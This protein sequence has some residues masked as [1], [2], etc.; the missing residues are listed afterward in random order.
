MFH[1]L[2]DL[3]V[4]NRIY[5]EALREDGDAQAGR[6]REAQKTRVRPCHGRDLELG[7]IEFQM[8]TGTTIPARDSG[9]ASSLRV[10]GK[11]RIAAQH[12]ILQMFK[13]K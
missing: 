4:H 5:L 11:G 10:V 3:G 1:A 13:N 7:A 9:A 6:Q 2:L 8:H 12:N